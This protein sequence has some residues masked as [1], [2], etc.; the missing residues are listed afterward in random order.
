VFDLTSSSEPSVPDLLIT[1]CFL[2][3]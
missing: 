3:R 2:D 1:L